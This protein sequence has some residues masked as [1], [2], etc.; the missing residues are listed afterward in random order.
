MPA[1]EVLETIFMA[2]K[3]YSGNNHTGFAFYTVDPATA[4]AI[5]PPI[6]KRNNEKSVQ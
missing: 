1:H 5:P 2:T 3:V 6:E 4:P